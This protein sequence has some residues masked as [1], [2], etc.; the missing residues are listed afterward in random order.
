MGFKM[1][2]FPMQSS[3]S[4]L[5][6]TTQASPFNRADIIKD[7]EVISKEDYKAYQDKAKELNEQ[8]DIHDL[9]GGG[10]EEEL[11]MLEEHFGDD[12]TNRHE[13][14]KE[15]IPGAKYKNDGYGNM[16]WYNADGTTL[17]PERMH[18]NHPEWGEYVRE[19]GDKYQSDKD[20]EYRAHTGIDKAQETEIGRELL[21][22]VGSAN[23][24][25][26]N[27]TLTG[28]D[29]LDSLREKFSE[30]HPYKNFDDVSGSADVGTLSF[31][32]KNLWNE[33]L[34]KYGATD[35]YTEAQAEIRKKA[36]E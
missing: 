20:D 11:A 22:K 18:V 12:M 21:G 33:F 23:Q 9:S 26:A 6:Q 17:T 3:V 5:K 4:A 14:I 31:E 35:A 27:V 32:N 13:W 24:P 29:T 16:Q 34:D 25:Y 36:M 10:S 30:E 2:G 1:K 8:R 7:G 15:N 28:Q 19:L